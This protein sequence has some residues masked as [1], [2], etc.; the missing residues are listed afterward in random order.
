MKP[1]VLT[2]LHEQK[3]I[4]CKVSPFS[5]FLPF[6]PPL[7]VLPTLSPPPYFPTPLSLPLLPLLPSLL[8]P[9]PFPTLFMYF[10]LPFFSLP[11]PSSLLPLSPSLFPL[12][13]SL[14]PLSPFL[15]PLPFL[16][17][18]SL[19]PFSSLPLSLPHSSV[20]W[21][22]SLRWHK[23][24]SEQSCT[25][26]CLQSV[27]THWGGNTRDKEKWAQKEPNQNW[28]HQLV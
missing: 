14:F 2:W 10:L 17:P 19:L 3:R 27:W 9:P 12:S 1:W 21:W 13:P 25:L 16:P 26:L 20:G 8:P 22:C 15:R 18:F 28:R 6:L 7:S 4:L 11:S 5:H 23:A 24:H